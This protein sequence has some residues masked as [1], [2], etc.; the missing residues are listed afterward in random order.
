MPTSSLLD[1]ALALLGEAK[2]LELQ[3]AACGEHSTSKSTELLD[4]SAK[5]YHEACYLMKRH[6]GRTKKG[7][8][9]GDTVKM[10]KLLME[11]IDHFELHAEDLTKRVKDGKLVDQLRLQQQLQNTNITEEPTPVCALE[12]NVSPKSSWEADHSSHLQ[13][14]SAANPTPPS[15]STNRPR[16]EYEEE[17]ARAA[18]KASTLLADAIES[19]ESGDTIAITQYAE[20]AQ[21]YLK[22]VKL[23]TSA[24]DIQTSGGETSWQSNP[25]QNSQSDSDEIVTLSLKRKIKQCLDRIEEL[26]KQSESTNASSEIDIIDM[27]PTVIS[28]S[29]TRPVNDENTQ[30]SLT[31]YEIAVLRRS[32]LIASGLFLPWSDEEA[33]TYKYFSYPK[34]WV[35]PDGLL[36]L[37]EMQKERFH[38][39][40][41][42]SEIIDMRRSTRSIHTTTM[43]KSISAYTIKQY[44]VSD[45]SFIAGLCIT[46]A[47][48]RR[49]QKRLVSSLIYPQDKATGMPIYNPNGVYM[50]KLWLNGVA[51]RV[52]VDDLLPVDE[53]G[54][55]L[56]S[57][58]VTLD[59]SKRNIGSGTLE[60]WVSI[61]EKAYMKLC[62]GYNFPGSN[63]GVDLFALTGWIPE[64][65][66]F[67]ED[68]TDVKDFETPTERAWNRLYR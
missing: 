22:A 54:D 10:Q 50:V 46:S 66:F 62:G 68:S 33:Q 17:V 45:C 42:P 60:L 35:D 9:N 55:L 2:E 38:K 4:E 64:R 43:V 6:I 63:S 39:W 8:D 19:E 26:K 11:N 25:S 52:L 13:T 47:F 57:H 3:A 32:S 7:S 16:H 67:P 34:P 48:E 21:Q 28:L 44:C 20:A 65:L 51:R 61:L 23:M 1:E 5:K 15:T 14:T 58:T 37:S 59:G 36:P 29:D 27:Q 12:R 53:R 24:K 49:F 40:A 56:C 30:Q 41:R 18:G 31:P